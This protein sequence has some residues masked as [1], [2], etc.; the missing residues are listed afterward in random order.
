MDKYSTEGI[1]TL[2]EFIAFLE[3]LSSST[4][5]LVDLTTQ[6]C[7]KYREYLL[8]DA[9]CRR[10]LDWFAYFKFLSKTDKLVK[11]SLNPEKLFD[12]KFSAQKLI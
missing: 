9:K 8:R 1:M 3:P 12:K 2:K 11:I 5:Q 7:N 10:C 4:D 6:I